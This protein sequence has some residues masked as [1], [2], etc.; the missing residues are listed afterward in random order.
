[1]AGITSIPLKWI[2]AC[3]A[4]VKGNTVLLLYFVLV[5]SKVE[6]LIPYDA[7]PQKEMSVCT[8]NINSKFMGHKTQGSN[9]LI[10][11]FFGYFI[12]ISSL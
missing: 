12:S 8:R 4:T 5:I 2:L 10:R 9:I 7:A 3:G 6:R 11:Q 1:M